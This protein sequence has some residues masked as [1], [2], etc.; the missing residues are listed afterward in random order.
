MIFLERFEFLVDVYDFTLILL[1]FSWSRYFG[2]RKTSWGFSLDH[3]FGDGSH[4]GS[5]KG[6]PLMAPEGDEKNLGGP[7]R[8]SAS[9]A[10]V[11]LDCC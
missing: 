8:R 9:C 4:K 5:N 7:S 6:E 2:F 3:A 10:S 1:V 11:P